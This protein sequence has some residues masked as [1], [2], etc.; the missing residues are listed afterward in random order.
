[1]SNEYPDITGKQLG[2]LISMFKLIAGLAITSITIV[3]AVALYV[4]YKDVKSMKE[5][6]AN[7]SSEMLTELK[8]I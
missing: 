7:R 8:E 1:M 3:T 5:D 4:S 2:Q 6:M